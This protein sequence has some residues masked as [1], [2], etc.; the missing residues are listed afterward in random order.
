MF[1]EKKLKVILK[2]DFQA[3]LLCF[4]ILIYLGLVLSR[5]SS[6]VPAFYANQVSSVSQLINI[7]F[8]FCLV[9]FDPSF[10]VSLILTLVK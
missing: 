3:K 1:Y 4:K 2:H 6:N 10:K 9:W 7:E 8:N 5:P